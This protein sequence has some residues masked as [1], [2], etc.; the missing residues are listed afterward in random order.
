VFHFPDDVNLD[1]FSNK[2]WKKILIDEIYNGVLS[3]KIIK[4]NSIFKTS[5]EAN[6]FNKYL[7]PYIS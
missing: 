7:L 5:Y 1:V 2:I 4:K 6:K 3:Y